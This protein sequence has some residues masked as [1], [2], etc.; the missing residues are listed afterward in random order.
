[1]GTKL[2]VISPLLTSSRAPPP[3]TAKASVTPGTCFTCR[4]SSA[5]CRSVSSSDV[6]A[7]IS[8]VTFTTLMSCWGM[9]VNLSLVAR[10]P[11]RT[12]TPTATATVTP[13]W[14]SSQASARR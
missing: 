1:M 7:G 14:S 5:S 2:T 4:D 9:K 12:S 3:A 13:R 8:M 10:N 6:P 11:V